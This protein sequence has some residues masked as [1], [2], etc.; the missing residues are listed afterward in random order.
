MKLKRTR[1]K[2]ETLYHVHKQKWTKLGPVGDPL[3]YRRYQEMEESLKTS[4][5]STVQGVADAY[6]A[7]LRAPD[8]PLGVK[9]KT[10]REYLRQLKQGS[11]LM[12]AFGGAPLEL[13]TRRMVNQ[14][15]RARSA[16]VAANREVAALSILFEWAIDEDLVGVNPVIGAKRNVEKP[17]TR[18]ISPQEFRVVYDHA[19]DYI[20]RAMAISLITSLRIGDILAIRRADFT[21]EYLTLRESK[22]GK[23]VR[24][25]MTPDLW[26]ALT[27]D[28]TVKPACVICTQKYTPYTSEGFASGWQRLMRRVLKKGLIAEKFTFHDIRALSATLREQRGDDVQVALGHSTAKQTET[29][30]R[31]R[32]PRYVEAVDMGGVMDDQ[33]KVR[34]LVRTGEKR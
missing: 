7:L 21:R 17:R 18:L 27:F 1:T 10:Q 11:P 24:Q 15:I 20:K 13:V 8:N 29:Y 28:G 5:I 4:P 2:G 16:K 6:S 34:K 14:Y 25:G 3:T 33:E 30:L 12:D 32:A 26:A 31:S 19:P 9:P 23:P 22:T